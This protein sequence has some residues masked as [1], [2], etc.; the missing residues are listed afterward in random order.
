MTSETV[1][2]S[3]EA[4]C[5]EIEIDDVSQWSCATSSKLFLDEVCLKFSIDLENDQRNNFFWKI[6]LDKRVP[7]T[8][9]LLEWLGYS[10]GELLEI[11]PQV[12]YHE[13]VDDLRKKKYLVLRHFD[14]EI[15]LMQM[16]TPKAVELRNIYFLIKTFYL[17]YWEYETYYETHRAELLQDRCNELT[18]ALKEEHEKVVA[19]TAECERMKFKLH[20]ERKLAK[21]DAETD[22]LL[23][24]L[25]KKQCH[26]AASH[27]L[28]AVEKWKKAEVELTDYKQQLVQNQ[29]LLDKFRQHISELQEQCQQVTKSERLIGEKWQQAEA[30]VKDYKWQLSVLQEQ[31]QQ[32]INREHLAK[33]T[34][35]RVEAKV[36]NYEGQIDQ[37]HILLDKCRRQIS[38]LQEQCQQVVKSESLANETR[39]WSEAIYKQQID[40][41]Q[42]QLDECRQKIVTLQEQ[43][44]QATAREQLVNKTWQQAETKF[45]E[46]EKQIS[47]LKREQSRSQLIVRQRQQAIERARLA[48]TKRIFAQSKHR[49][50]I[51]REQQAIERYREMNA[52]RIRAMWARR[53]ANERCQRYTTQLENS[54]EALKGIALNLVPPPINASKHHRFGLFK[55]L[56]DGEYYIMRRQLEKWAVTEYDLVQNRGMTLLKFWDN[57]S[58]AVALGN[59]VKKYL[60][61]RSFYA[62]DNTI[63]IP[64]EYQQEVGDDELVDMIERIISNDIP[65]RMLTDLISGMLT[66]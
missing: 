51:C 61:Q 10:E 36:A 58:H 7:V 46:Y 21:L 26:Q 52:K 60:R 17:K 41:K 32:V 62:R 5:R 27:E 63:R 20:G 8:E 18:S 40:L 45:T 4:K 34:C 31:Y 19:K 25:L 2:S 43:C 11:N 30:M 42:Q 6:Q 33:E 15:L 66:N 14:F 24:S 23:E 13:I 54:I 49:L 53:Q 48:N 22:Q 57:V 12:K 28:L 3:V 47:E 16:R 38:V 44:H 29:Q 9:E 55:T 35:Q 59:T 50:S 65:E 1:I 39:E 56:K 64:E 37:N